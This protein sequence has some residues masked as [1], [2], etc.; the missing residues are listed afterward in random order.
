VSDFSSLTLNS[1][2]A[3]KVKKRKFGAQFK[4]TDFLR[5]QY[6]IERKQN[7]EQRS[8]TVKEEGK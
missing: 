6:S 5:R 1:Q 4:K 7:G 3:D 2:R 8:P